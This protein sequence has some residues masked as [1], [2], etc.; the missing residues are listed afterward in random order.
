METS[1]QAYAGLLLDRCRNP[2]S[3]NRRD[4]DWQ[5][6]L[7]RLFRSAAAGF[8]RQSTHRVRLLCVDPAAFPHHVISIRQQIGERFHQSAWPTNYNFVR[9]GC[10]T[11]TEMQS[12]VALRNVAISAAN[13]FLAL[14]LALLECDRRSQRGPV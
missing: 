11:Q 5:C 4:F 13:F 7:K 9:L 6:V 8:D 3:S 10:L 1:K 2:D 12:Q 14:V